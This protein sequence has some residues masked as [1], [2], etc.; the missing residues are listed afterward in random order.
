[1]NI[2]YKEEMPRLLALIMSNLD[3]GLKVM[4]LFKNYTS[5]SFSTTMIS[6]MHVHNSITLVTV[7]KLFFHKLFRN[8]FENIFQISNFKRREIPA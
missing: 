1:M 8:H 5:E 2:I 7:R 4:H 6:I 3:R